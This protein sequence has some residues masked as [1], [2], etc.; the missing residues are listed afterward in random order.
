MKRVIKQLLRE[1]FYKPEIKYLT[2]DEMIKYEKVVAIDGFGH[3]NERRRYSDITWLNIN[4]IKVNKSLHGNHFNKDD[5]NYSLNIIKGGEELPP[6]LV[7]YDYTILDGYN[8]FKAAKQLGV[9]QIPV[10]IHSEDSKI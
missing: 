4:K 2:N 7:D 3:E 10:I 8:R 9:K 5:Y 1:E 6:I